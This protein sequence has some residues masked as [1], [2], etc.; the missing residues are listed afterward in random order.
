MD[1][2]LADLGNNKNGDA[3][4]KAAERL[5]ALR[6]D[7][8]RPLVAK[9][10]AESALA[11]ELYNRTAL[12]R[13]LGTWA[14]AAEVP[15]LLELLSDKDVNTRNEVLR[16]IGKLRDERTVEPVV[17]CFAEL[18]TR[19]H[20][21]RALKAMGPIAEEQVLAL[22]REPD[23][24]LWVPAIGILKE[25]G[26]QRSIPTLEAASRGDV[27]TQSPAKEAIAA[28]NARTKK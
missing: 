26:T 21:E 25:I 15:A 3:Q 10:L 20:G 27:S 23:K 7:R 1:R 9:K 13:A 17:G 28:I 18:A 19:Y 5:A 22:L 6:P 8:H 14:T 4:R 16:V 2:S 11:V 24:A 12:I